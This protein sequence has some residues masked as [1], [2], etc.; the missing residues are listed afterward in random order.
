MFFHQ[1]E[2]NKV[3]AAMFTGIRPAV[4]ALIGVML[5]MLKWLERVA[6]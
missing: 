1:F 2:D 4:V 3:V 5:G 6:E